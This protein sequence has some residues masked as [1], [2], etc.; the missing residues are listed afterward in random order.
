MGALC[1]TTLNEQESL[2]A[3][4]SLTVQVTVVVPTG[5]LDPLGGE[6]VGPVSGDDPS[7]A[8]AGP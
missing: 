7:V 4:A 1:T 8:V 2:R 3:L 6:Q 5:N